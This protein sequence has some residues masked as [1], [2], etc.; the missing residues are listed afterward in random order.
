MMF[1]LNFLSVG[2]ES[3]KSTFTVSR[4]LKEPPSFLKIIFQR[5]THDMTT[6]EAIKNELKVAITLKRNY[7]IPSSNDKISYTL[8]S[9][10][11]H[12]GDSLDCGHSV[13]DVFDANKVI[14]WHYD[15]GNI[16]HISDFTKRGYIRESQ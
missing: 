9:L 3:I 6:D 4:Y 13:S 11:N 12:D 2:S 10:I 5:G 16:T 1:Y 7:K 8:L 14:W 15:D